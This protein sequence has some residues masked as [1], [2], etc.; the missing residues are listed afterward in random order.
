MRRNRNQDKYINFILRHKLLKPNQ[1]IW[2]VYWFMD[3]RGYPRCFST[4]EYEL[5][6]SKGTTRKRIVKDLLLL[7]ILKT[8]GFKLFGKRP[9]PIFDF[10][11]DFELQ[12]AEFT[13]SPKDY[14][15]EDEFTLPFDE[16]FLQDVSENIPYD[17]YNKGTKNQSKQG[18]EELS[19]S[20]YRLKYPEVDVSALFEN[21]PSDID[22]N[23][24]PTITNLITRTV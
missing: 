10:T 24:D 4:T 19:P 13:R 11:E 5:G 12:V 2:L 23:F 15:L 14:W 18:N 22:Q 7:N 8:I 16:K 9:T 1:K 21:E 6:F 20:D 3:Q 17:L